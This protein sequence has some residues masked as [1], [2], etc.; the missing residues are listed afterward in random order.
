MAENTS[1][2][3]TVARVRC[4]QRALWQRGECVP[5]ETRILID[6]VLDRVTIRR[7]PVAFGL[8]KVPGKTY[9]QTLREKLRWGTT[10]N[11]RHEPDAG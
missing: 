10:P 9:Y 7:A 2:A 8:V 3:E 5:V 6:G 1:F 4:E 11:Y